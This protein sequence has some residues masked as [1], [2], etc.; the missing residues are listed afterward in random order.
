MAR[1]EYNVQHTGE[2]IKRRFYI[3]GS[4]FPVEQ[5]ALA[6]TILYIEQGYYRTEKGNKR[7]LRSSRNEETDQ[8][9]TRGHS[10]KA[11]AWFDKKSITLLKSTYSVARY[12]VWC[13]QKPSLKPSPRR[14]LT[15]RPHGLAQK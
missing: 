3:P 14:R 5:L 11:M 7:R 15:I 13:L 8:S 2:E 9:P 12:V 6:A 1:R 4:T 10:K